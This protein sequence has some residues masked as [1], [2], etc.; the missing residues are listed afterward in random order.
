MLPPV[1]IPLGRRVPADWRHV[2]R[3]PYAVATPHTVERFLRLPRYR[4]EYDQGPRNACVGY[5]ATWMMSILNRRRYDPEWL[6]N[7]AK[8]RDV[9]PATVFGDASQTTL[10]AALDVLRLEGHRHRVGDRD[11]P[12]SP[13]D[14]IAENRW[15][16]TVDEVRASIA[17]G[18]PVV[19]GINWYDTF[20]QPSRA[21]GRSWIGRGQL[22]RVLGGHAI[23]VYGASDRFG[24]VA[25]V[26]SFG[27]SYPLTLLPYEAL[28]R[29][30]DEDGEATLVTDRG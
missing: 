26:N 17:S 27:P 5:A 3:Y 2:E 21:G 19:L 30:L 20:E 15:A 11:L 10:R 23:C 1:R 16:R 18:V 24:A 12:P 13:A 25:V 29:L 22:G 8:T 14:G 4:R 6:W 9:S 28:A 7:E